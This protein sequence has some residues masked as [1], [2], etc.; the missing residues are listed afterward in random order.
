MEFFDKLFSKLK[1][2][3]PVTLLTFLSLS[4]VSYVAGLIR[5]FSVSEFFTG[6]I[7]LAFITIIF[8]SS[9]GGASDSLKKYGKILFVILLCNKIISAVNAPFAFLEA[10]KYTSG[11]YSI[12]VILTIMYLLALVAVGVLTIMEYAYSKRRYENAI[13]SLITIAF[14][15]IAIA[16]IF[17]IISSFVVVGVVWYLFLTPLLNANFVLVYYGFREYLIA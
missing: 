8:I 15:L 1:A 12:Y 7:N 10:V 11:A 13:K 14:G 16:F 3:L 2:C 17:A 4:L 9:A 5:A 6:L